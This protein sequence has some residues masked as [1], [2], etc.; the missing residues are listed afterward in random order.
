MQIV[1]SQ[2]KY[3]VPVTRNKAKTLQ[4]AKQLCNLHV[5]RR[6]RGGAVLIFIFISEPIEGQFH[7]VLSVRV[8]RMTNA[9]IHLIGDETGNG[10]REE[11]LEF[12]PSEVR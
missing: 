10:H 2:G 6:T 8:M 9:M 3:I 12:T 11:V 4:V 1:K 7:G 5:L